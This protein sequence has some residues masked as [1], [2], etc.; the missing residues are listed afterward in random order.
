MW[1]GFAD[2]DEIEHGTFNIVAS[3]SGEWGGGSLGVRTDQKLLVKDTFF[4]ER[5]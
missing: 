2:S 5:F 1:F 3:P 4:P